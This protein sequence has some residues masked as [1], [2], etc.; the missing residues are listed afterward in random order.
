MQ[1]T[2]LI[3]S[4]LPAR[5]IEF[6]DVFKSWINCCACKFFEIKQSELIIIKAKF[7]IYIKTDG[8]NFSRCGS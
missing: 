6:C 8:R 1:I 7:V 4:A 3:G 5:L 2:I